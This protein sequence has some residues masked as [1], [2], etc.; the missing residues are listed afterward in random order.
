[1]YKKKYIILK[2]LFQEIKE[3]PSIIF[4]IVGTFLFWV[5]L[6]LYVPILP[7]HA[8]AIGA[9]STMIGYIIASYA[10]GQMFLR[11]P[12]GYAVDKWG[13]KPFAILT[14][15]C[16]AAGSFGLAIADNSFEI[17]LARLI[18]GV[19]GA[20]WVA[21]SVL[22]ASQFKTE[23]LH[24]ATSFMMGINGIAITMATLISG[25]MAD[26]FG[27][28][29]P[30]YSSVCVSILGIFV[31]FFSKEPRSNT[32]KT[33]NLMHIIKNN[34]LLRVSIIAIGFHF[35][36]FGVTLG[37]LPIIIE[38]LGGSKTN[39]GDITTLSQL[40][41]IG[42]MSLSAFFI[43]RLGIRITIFLGSI[44]MFCSLILT[45]YVQNLFII[46]ALQ[47]VAGFGR[48]ILYTV[49]ITL[50]LTSFN[51][52]SRGLAM[53]AYQAFYAIGMF[54]GP[55]LSGLIVNLFGI[56]AIFWISSL[57]TLIAMII[58]VYKPYKSNL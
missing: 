37:F 8:K 19:A 10:I 56:N 18:T 24:Y 2:Y 23:F 54:L 47:F 16:S 31:L 52:E 40:A 53:G 48:G 20:G 51:K 12:L 55:A 33:I 49:T 43:N 45:A 58:G 21:I 46:A 28:S 22:F 35:V 7:N 14:M 32:H 9:S 36:T 17:F 38:N 26:M 25:R 57:I 39:I 29:T 5:S 13:T 42:G 1:M 15:I 27:I 44:S 11:I 41:A 4:V 50:I 3:N 30:F 34:T 6:Y